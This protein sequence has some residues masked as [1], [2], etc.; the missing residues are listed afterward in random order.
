[1]AFSVLSSTNT[2]IGGSAAG[3]GNVIAAST[4]IGFWFDDGNGITLSFTSGNRVQ[5]NF[6]G[7]NKLGTGVL[8]NAD[9]GIGMYNSTGDIIGGSLP[10]EGNLI[11][12]N[13]RDGLQIASSSGGIIQGNRIGSNASGTALLGSQQVGMMFHGGTSAFTIGGASD[14]STGSLTGA[15]NLVV[16]STTLGMGVPAGSTV[17]GNVV[18][19]DITGKVDLGNDI[20]IQGSGSL[21][22]G[23]APQYRNVISG[24][25]HGLYVERCDRDRR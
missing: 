11:S 12:G 17:Q 14:W 3:A 9:A 8:G 19:L 22:G 2:Q 5:G 7:T 4:D 24:N 18:G 10:G 13:A 16:G 21:I 15:G 23:S 20:G 6:I 25:R 1:M